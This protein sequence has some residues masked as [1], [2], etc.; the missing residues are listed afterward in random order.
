M[1]DHLSLSLSLWAFPAFVPRHSQTFSD[2]DATI[3]L[4]LQR[5][6]SNLYTVII[7]PLPVMSAALLLTAKISATL[8]VTMS[9]IATSS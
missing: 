4:V 1:N 6:S 7:E 8:F 5:R 2:K 3:A 9:A